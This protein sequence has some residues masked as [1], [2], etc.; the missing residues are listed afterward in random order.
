ME[1]ITPVMKLIL[2]ERTLFTCHTRSCFCQILGTSLNQN[3]LHMLHRS[4]ISLST[5]SSGKRQEQSCTCYIAHT[6]QSETVSVYQ[7]LTVFYV[8]LGYSFRHYES[9]ALQALH[10][11]P[12]CCQTLTRQIENGAE[13]HRSHNIRV[14]YM[15]SELQTIF[16]ANESFILRNQTV[17]ETL[18]ASVSVTERGTRMLFHL[19]Q[20]FCP[21]P[22]GS[23][24]LE[25]TV[26]CRQCGLVVYISRLISSDQ[27]HY[28][29]HGPF[30][31][32]VDRLKRSCIGF[33]STFYLVPIPSQS[34]LFAVLVK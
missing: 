29:R 4:S 2:N 7:L 32:V 9:T 28:C 24:C 20:Q 34:S 11:H 5:W 23:R 12:S 22:D 21:R 25:F 18:D 27:Y 15:T 33:I 16:S 13:Q 6:N 31:F 30:N 14:A 26:S 19:I 10:W 8:T 1:R 17:Y 3:Y